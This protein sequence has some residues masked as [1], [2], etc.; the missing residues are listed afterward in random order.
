MPEPVELVAV[1]A[2]AGGVEALSSFVAG[3]PADLPAS[4]LVVLHVSRDAPTVL[5]RILSRRGALPA[6]PAADGLE[7]LPGHLYVGVP[8]CHT[9]VED[10]RVRLDHGPRENGHRPA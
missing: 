1:G 10:G 7:L 5:D 3:L 8:D 6:Q 9:V 2:S 4:V